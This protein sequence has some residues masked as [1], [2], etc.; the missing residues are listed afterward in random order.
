MKGDTG[1]LLGAQIIGNAGVDK[2][3]DVFATAITLGARIYTVFTFVKCT[4]D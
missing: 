4:V 1:K 2:R 3:I